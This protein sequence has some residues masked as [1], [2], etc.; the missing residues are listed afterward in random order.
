MGICRARSPDE[1]HAQIIHSANGHRPGLMR[2]SS[3]PRL[4][5]KA[6]KPAREFMDTV[7]LTSLNSVFGQ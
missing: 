5:Y 1:S 6:E 7:I 3:S 2:R 4:S